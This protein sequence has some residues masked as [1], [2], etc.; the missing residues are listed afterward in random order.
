MEIDLLKI[1]KD[2]GI[3][4]LSGFTAVYEKKFL[5][6]SGIL[7]L[8]SLVLFYDN[9]GSSYMKNKKFIQF[10]ENEFNKDKSIPFY[11]IMDNNMQ[12]YSGESQL[13]DIAK[14]FTQLTRID[15]KIYKEYK[16]NVL[17]WQVVIN[18]M[19]SYVYQLSNDVENNNNIK[20]KTDSMVDKN[21]TENGFALLMQRKQNFD[22]NPIMKH[23]SIYWKD[24]LNQ[25][26]FEN[27]VK[28]S[29]GVNATLNNTI[30]KI[31]N[32]NSGKITGIRL[33]KKQQQQLIPDSLR[34]QF[35]IMKHKSGV[36]LLFIESNGEQERLKK[37]T[38]N[39]TLRFYKFY[40][41]DQIKGF[42]D[43]YKLLNITGILDTL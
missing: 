4:I 25:K 5:L 41:K 21:E 24:G 3:F 7:C 37:T 27:N 18:D 34:G 33:T 17:I 31:I 29:N 30:N 43:L 6:L 8:F 23:I 9:F 15:L 12:H 35:T 42:T 10:V 13:V 1:L 22:K 39:K 20:N 19:P 2:Y 38:K 40:N 36:I 28:N 32:K 11:D 26:T 16:K 14:F